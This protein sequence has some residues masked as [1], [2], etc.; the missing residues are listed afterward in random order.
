MV[1]RWRLIHWHSGTI[2]LFSLKIKTVLNVKFSNVSYVVGIYLKEHVPVQ[3]SPYRRTL[4]Y[5]NTYFFQCKIT[6]TGH[7]QGENHQVHV[8]KLHW[9]QS[10][11]RN[12]RYAQLVKKFPA[13]NGTR[14]FSN[15]HKSPPPVHILSHFKSP[16]FFRFVVPLINFRFLTGI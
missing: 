7:A 3:A 13:F 15:V 2:S 1:V 11:L 16:E 9:A 10:F 14:R 8:T 6:F 12:L 5:V 4:Y